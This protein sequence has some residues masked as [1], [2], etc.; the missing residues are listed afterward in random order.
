MEDF[1]RYTVRALRQ[2]L[3]NA[4]LN[5]EGS[6]A[7]LVSRATE[8]S[9]FIYEQMSQSNFVEFY[10]AELSTEQAESINQEN[11]NLIEGREEQ[12]TADGSI[13]QELRDIKHQL[14]SLQ[15]EVYSQ[16]RTI[17]SL[18]RELNQ[19]RQN[20]MSL[21]NEAQP[22]MSSVTPTSLRNMPFRNDRRNSRNEDRRNS[23]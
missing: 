9:R 4:S 13:Q 16:R 5:T 11:M 1:D 12:Q 17:E 6:R 2:L 10:A 15:R 14:E 21:S 20:N 19:I 23:K 22:S 8:Y 18:Q 3:R 7:E